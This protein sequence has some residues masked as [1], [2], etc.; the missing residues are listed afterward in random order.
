MQELADKLPGLDDDTPIDI[1]ENADGDQVLVFNFDLSKVF[2]PKTVKLSLAELG[3]ADAG[4]AGITT[5][6]N[7]S[8]AAQ[9]GVTFTAGVV[10]EDNGADVVVDATT[11]I[12]Q[13]TPFKEPKPGQP[14]VDRWDFLNTNGATADVKITLRSGSQHQSQRPV[15]D[16]HVATTGR[17]AQRGDRAELC[18][19]SK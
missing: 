18:Q 16:E 3:G 19:D 6:S 17:R 10:L 7:V 4:I 1:V 13:I 15:F 5:S 14:E 2:T 9:V 11:P 8:L 12:K